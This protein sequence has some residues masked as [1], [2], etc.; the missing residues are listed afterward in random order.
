M[1]RYCGRAID[2][3]EHT[4]M[5]CEEWNVEREELKVA[6]DKPVNMENITIALC[7]G[8]DTWKTV[9]KFAQRIIRRKEDD[10]RA[11]QQRKK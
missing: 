4:L 11:E 10:E 9:N 2:N 7:S 3:A 8:E 6:M 1:C 5:E